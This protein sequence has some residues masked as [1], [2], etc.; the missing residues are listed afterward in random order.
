MK[1]EAGVESITTG[2]FKKIRGKKREKKKIILAAIWELHTIS[3]GI[4]TFHG[5]DCGRPLYTTRAL[6]SGMGVAIRINEYLTCSL[7]LS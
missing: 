7:D 4:I 6:N 3:V 5:R 2:V 1:S